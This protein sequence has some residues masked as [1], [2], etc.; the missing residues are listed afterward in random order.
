MKFNPNTDGTWAASITF[1]GRAMVAEGKTVG[2][3]R[4]ALFVL[5]NARH[6]EIEGQ[7]NAAR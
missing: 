7:Q 6:R 4:T 2:L 1:R 5:M 3:A